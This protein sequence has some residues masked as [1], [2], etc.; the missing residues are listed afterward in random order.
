[1]QDSAPRNWP[2]STPQTSDVVDLNP[3]ASTPRNNPSKTKRFGI[4]LLLAGALLSASALS[5]ITNDSTYLIGEDWEKTTIVPKVLKMQVLGR[6]SVQPSR[7][8]SIK[9][10]IESNRARIVWLQEEGTHVTAGE[11]IAKFDKRPFKEALEL[12]Q[13]RSR[14][15]QAQVVR[16]E[17][18]LAL[19]AE[20]HA[21]KTEAATRL[22]EVAGIEV[23]DAKEGSGQVE[24]F[25]LYAQIKQL[26]RGLRIAQVEHDDYQSLFTQG[27]ISRKELEVAVDALRNATDALHLGEQELQGFERFTWPKRKREASLKFEAAKTELARVERTAL[28]ER[29]R[30]E[31]EQRKAA[32]EFA[33]AR[34]MVEKTSW[35]LEHTDLRAPIS[36]VVLHTEVPHGGKQR[37]VQ[38]GDALWL[39]QSFLKIPDTSDLDVH[40]FVRETDVSKIHVGMHARIEL[41]A[42]I[43]TPV[44]GVVTRVATMASNTESQRDFLVEVRFNTSPTEVHPGMSANVAIEHA[45]TNA[46]MAVPMS[47]LLR[48]DG[49]TQLRVLSDDSEWHLKPVTLGVNN[50]EWAQVLEGVS[51]GDQVAIH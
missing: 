25:R 6:G 27:H 44:D 13:Q 5:F 41:D 23:A 22:M 51:H 2:T 31:A 29:D 46:D 21:S 26:Q 48:A 9:S 28:L 30:L 50:G 10:P 45:R 37:K 18:A 11:L 33:V 20:E 12:A 39:G 32:Q 1:M 19:A 4:A 15:A 35:E 43:G 47:A 36:G 49:Q 7:V 24:S 3:A 14:E 16:A 38:V 8:V 42:F 40:V 34:T 17:K